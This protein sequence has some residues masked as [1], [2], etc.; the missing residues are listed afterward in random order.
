VAAKAKG[1][2]I[3]WH[4]ASVLFNGSTYACQTWESTVE[5]GLK[6]H[7]SQDAAVAGVQRMPEAVTPGNQKVSLT[8]EFKAP[9]TVDFLVDIPASVTLV[10]VASNAGGTATFS[11]TVGALHPVGM[12]TKIA[13]GEDDVTWSVECEADYDDLTAW[14]FTLA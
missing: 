1:L 2:M 12:P 10:F 13:S 9:P 8:A 14:T 6:L 7:T 5:N 4:D 11:H 3:L